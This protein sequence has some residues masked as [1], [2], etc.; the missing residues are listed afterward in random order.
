MGLEDPL[1]FYDAIITSGQ[2]L[3]PGQTGTLGELETKPHPWPYAEA[4]RLGLGIGPEERPHCFGIEDSGAGVCSIRLA[5]F[6]AVGVA[7]GNIRRAGVTD[8]LHHYKPTL[9]EVLELL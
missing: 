6:A 2:A 7:H 4:A 3:R 8:L 9:E 5:G 1:G